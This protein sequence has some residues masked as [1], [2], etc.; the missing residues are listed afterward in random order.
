[1]FKPQT[2]ARILYNERTED[3][4][5]AVLKFTECERL[6]S[7]ASR[8]IGPKIEIDCLGA[9]D[10]ALRYLTA[11]VTLLFQISVI[12]YLIHPV[13]RS[14]IRKLWHDTRDQGCKT[15]V[16]WVTEQYSV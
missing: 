10:K 9:A 8:V 16:N 5:T 13:C 6:L 15:A 4:S 7:Y 1:M 14:T 12:I 3:P 11:T 2:K